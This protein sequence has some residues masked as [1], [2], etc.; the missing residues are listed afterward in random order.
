VVDATFDDMRR[1]LLQFGR[2]T[3]G[4]EMA[5]VFFAGHGMEIAGEN[6]LI[7]I[8]AELRSDNDAEG[9]A[10][11]LR[12]AMLQVA[13]A[14]TLGLV[15]LD[16]CRNN[17]FAAKMQRSARYR[18]VDR[19]LARIEPTDNVLVAYASKDGTTAN[20][21]TGKNSPFTAALLNNLEVSGIEIRFLLASVR[22][23]VMAVTKR[24]QQPFVYGSLSKQAIYLKEP[25]KA[26]Q[27][28]TP[29]PAPASEAAQAW[30]AVGDTAS[31]VVLEDFVRRFGE[32]IYGTLARDRMEE[33]KR[34][35]A[36]VETPPPPAAPHPAPA[37]PVPL[38]QKPEPSKQQQFGAAPPAVQPAEAFFQRQFQAFVEWEKAKNTS[39]VAAV[40][41]FIRRYGDTASGTDAR[42]RLEELKK[43]RVAVVAPPV[44]PSVPCGAGPT[45]ASLSSSSCPLS[46]AE[47]R[48]LK[49]KDVFK[50]CEKCPEMVVVQAGHFT[51]G[52][53][54][55]ED[56]RSNDEGPQH[57]VTIANSFAVGRF[58][59]TFDEWDQCLAEGGCNGY[60]PSDVGWGR[61]RHPVI[62]VSFD[63]AKAYLTW[64]SRKTGKTYR[65][66]SEAEREYVTRAGT[67]TPFWWGSSISTDQANYDGSSFSYGGGPKG[68]NRHRTLPVD[69]FQ[70]NPWGLYQVHGN[71]WDWVED[72]WHE[73]YRGAPSDGSAWVS[74]DCKEH[75]IRGGSWYGK[76]WY[77]RSAIR[78]HNAADY[79]NG[80]ADHGF[81]VARTL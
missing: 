55:S 31:V 72:C 51:M 53:P 16:A 21:G 74:G 18:A 35:Q 59:V 24:E 73:N 7:P 25:A 48:A 58:A 11:P 20:D 43:G 56:G 67:T 27:E 54:S 80:N 8:D 5:V 68:E 32:T 75:V 36:A 29:A 14:S 49:P 69:A 60:R 79:R 47:E 26:D 38:A 42:A 57:A 66:L 44:V 70:S 78:A 10:I 12:S 13:N 71:V 22:D 4:A 40:E 64:L 3:R 33:L 46:T 61:G 28:K 50:E 23:E 9:E 81:R 1:A 62:N 63:D 41:D 37:P 77:L 34:K 17:P 15:I 19:G 45:V 39:N 76:A 52:S 30:S 6:W 2:E 65:L